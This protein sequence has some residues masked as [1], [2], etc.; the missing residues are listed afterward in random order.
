MEDWHASLPGHLALN[1][2][3][4]YV[5]EEQ[6]TLGAFFAL[7]LVYH[8]SRVDLARATLAGYSFPIPSTLADT[9]PEFRAHY[10]ERAF[11]HA[12]SVSSILGSGLVHSPSCFDDYSA[13]T[14][15][16]EST[17]V[18]IIYATTVAWADSCLHRQIASNIHTNLRVLQVMYPYMDMPNV[19]VSC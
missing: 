1:N 13:S 15:A 7:H 16:F 14:A 9:S 4:F 18:Q 3:N 10:Q 5:H 12:A 8:S 17:K 2:A 6:Q 11:H 19:Y